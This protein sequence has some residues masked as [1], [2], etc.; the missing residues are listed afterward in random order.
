M[1]PGQG[2]QGDA[3]VYRVDARI[4]GGQPCC[5][6]QVQDQGLPGQPPLPDAPQGPRPEPDRG[7][8]S[9][10]RRGQH[11]SLGGLDTK[12]ISALLGHSRTSF[13]DASYVLLF[14]EVAKAAAES[15]AAMVPRRRSGTVD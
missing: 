11:H 12:F 3:S 10:V 9:T 4:S 14:P 13:T 5:H 2:L 6:R 15:A 8:V 1:H 7:V